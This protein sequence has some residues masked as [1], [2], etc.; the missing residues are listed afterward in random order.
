MAVTEKGGY[1][2]R[3]RMRT[4][5][6]PCL[7]DVLAGEGEDVTGAGTV[8][9]VLATL[10][11]T[12]LVGGRRGAVIGECAPAYRKTGA[13]VCDRCGEGLQ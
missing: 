10:V 9:G 4:Y 2:H 13:K 6:P 7:L 8:D 3:N 1:F 5:C 11:R 12:R